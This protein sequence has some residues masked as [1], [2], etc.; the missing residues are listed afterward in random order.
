MKADNKNYPCPTLCSSAVGCYS[1]RQREVGRASHVFEPVYFVLFLCGRADL[2]CLR[3]GG[4]RTFR[5]ECC[6]IIQFRFCEL[7][8]YRVWASS[9]RLSL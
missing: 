7:G 1:K 9:I 2:S 8:F 3:C 4:T 6:P 5:L